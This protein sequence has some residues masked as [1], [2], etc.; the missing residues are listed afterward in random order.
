[1]NGDTRLRVDQ[2]ADDLYAS[3][4]DDFVE[5]RRA[6]AIALRDEGDEPGAKQ[7]RSMPKP[8]VSAWAINQLWWS[9][10]KPFESLF[11]ATVALRQSA[12]ARPT[13]EAQ[14]RVM[15]DAAR[16]LLLVAGHGGSPIL[17]RRVATTL[18]AIAAAGSFAPDANGRLVADRDPPGFESMEGATWALKGLKEDVPS[19][20]N[21][22]R[23][24]LT[25]PSYAE[26]KARRA[27]DEKQRVVLA[28][29]R[30]LE[31]LK[32]Q[33]AQAESVIARAD[34]E[35]ETLA[36]RQ[37]KLEAERKSIESERAQAETDAETVR[38]RMAEIER[39]LQETHARPD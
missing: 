1:V 10:R 37:A 31:A 3:A 23:P 20:E 11:A 9:D 38:A 27:A 24:N 26:A 14:I 17:L 21:S 16:D 22:P 25:A 4:L 36:I 18:H 15:R 39:F 30:E 35:L 8:S 28:T 19:K 34:R 33:F 29:K 12:N 6:L 5:R 13:F 32:S 7:V 2:V